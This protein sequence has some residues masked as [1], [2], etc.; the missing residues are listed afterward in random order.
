MSIINNRSKIQS[1]VASDAY[2]EGWD[3]I[4]GKKTKAKQCGKAFKYGT[5]GGTC[6]CILDENHEG[7]CHLYNGAV[8]EHLDELLNNKDDVIVQPCVTMVP[9]K[10][11]EMHFNLM[12]TVEDPAKVTLSFR[13]EYMD[14]KVFETLE[15]AEAFAKTFEKA[16]VKQVQEDFIGHE[17]V[18]FGWRRPPLVSYD[19]D[20]ASNSIVY[21]ATW[22]GLA[23]VKPKDQTAK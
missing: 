14:Q 3:R 23:Y 18:F 21:K 9:W 20:F 6:F 4:F 10:E 22:R 5:H 15:E 1:E 2:R 12:Q 7:P 13:K 17:E 8:M 16:L 11:A 19:R